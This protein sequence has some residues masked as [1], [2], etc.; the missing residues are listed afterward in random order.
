MAKQK[1]VLQFRGKLGQV[2]GMKN[3]FGGSE[4][5]AR[6][7]VAD[8]KNPQTA[9]QTAQ[10]IR[11]LPA[12]NF[13]RQLQSVIARAW[14]G[15]KY[16]GASTRKFMKYALKEPLNNIP[17]VM[18]DE[19]LAI[20]GKYL[21]S[22]GSLA[23]ITTEFSGNNL[24]FG[25]ACGDWGSNDNI[26]EKWTLG[27]LTRQL[28]DNNTGMIEDGDQLTVICCYSNDASN[29]ELTTVLYS[30]SSIVLNLNSEA[31]LREIDAGFKGIDEGLA[32]T[33]NKR[34]LGGCIVLSREGASHLRNTTRFEINESDTQLKAFFSD[35][36][37]ASV[38]RSYTKSTGA[39]SVNWP[40]EESEIEDDVID[41]APFLVTVISNNDTLGTV[42]GG[43]TYKRGDIVTCQATA[44]SGA[45]FEKWK[46][47]GESVG[48]DPTLQ[49][50]A[51]GPVTI[52]AHFESEDRP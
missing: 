22:R 50:E 45:I 14:E 19:S 39:S 35:S 36:L 42:T 31:D 6:S 15:T 20:P 34:L 48:D 3:G 44:L 13:R 4:A 46:I 27:Y 37:K 24:V 11:L 41:D 9:G 49:Y 47:N 30:V 26:S 7:Y 52:V 43:G 21:V 16:G 1:S 18:K 12:V 25:L 28:I 23:S 10:R 32:Y 17:Q 2:V 29:A 33:K 51:Q 38:K 8:P 40:Y 5:F